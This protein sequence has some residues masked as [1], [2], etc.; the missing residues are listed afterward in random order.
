MP[1]GLRIGII[2]AVVIGFTVGYTSPGHRLL[3]TIGSKTACAIAAVSAWG[4]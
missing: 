3:K 1:R 2:A 4:C